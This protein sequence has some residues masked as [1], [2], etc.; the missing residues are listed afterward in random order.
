MSP[1]TKFQTN[2]LN[3]SSLCS[4]SSLWYTVSTWDAGLPSPVESKSWDE[5]A[6]EEK[7]GAFFLGYLA[8]R[9]GTRR[10]KRG[11]RRLDFGFQPPPSGEGNKFEGLAGL[12]G[13]ETAAAAE[14][15]PTVGEVTVRCPARNFGICFVGMK[16]NR[17]WRRRRIMMGGAR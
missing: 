8:R 2:R 9:R 12:T 4:L 5:M 1:W 16:K 15:G 7:F 11:E 14:E 10:A 3:L 17:F 6:A 13:G